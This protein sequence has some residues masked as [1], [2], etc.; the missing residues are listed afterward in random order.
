MKTF[1]SL[2]EFRK[3][4]QFIS[5]KPYLRK[6]IINVGKV[7]PET[8]FF[9]GTYQKNRVYFRNEFIGNTIKLD[10][11]E[12][13]TI[14]QSKKIFD[15]LDNI[16]KYSFCVSSQ[17]VDNTHG[18]YRFSSRDS[19]RTPEYLYHSTDVS[20]DIIMT[21]GIKRN[22]SLGVKAFPPLVFVGTEKCWKGKY[23]Y[24][25]KTSKKLYVDTNLDWQARDIKPYLC[26]KED[27]SPSEIIDFKL[28]KE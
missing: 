19:I 13:K 2:A 10:Q 5:L 4:P 8:E 24:K 23:T 11:H 1:S 16:S 15:L 3:L 6:S 18:F 26:L 7:F 12:L 27:V 9:F 22:Y 25:I 14:S 20:P 21:E 28:S 17:G